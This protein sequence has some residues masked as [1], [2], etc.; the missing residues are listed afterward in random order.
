METTHSLPVQRIPR[1]QSILAKAQGAYLAVNRTHAPFTMTTKTH[2][3]VYA[4]LGLLIWLG[5]QVVGYAL[6][7]F[8]LLL[9][10]SK[11]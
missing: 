2:D 6:A 4:A 5:A 11:L 3:L 8:V 9:F 7:A 10:I 1:S